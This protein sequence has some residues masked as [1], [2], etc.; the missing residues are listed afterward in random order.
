MVSTVIYNGDINI[1]SPGLYEYMI[2]DLNGRIINKGRIA[3]GISNIRESK[4]INGL[5]IIRFANGEGQW[6]EKFVSH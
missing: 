1:S 3:N 2:L 6:T 4:L 5:Y